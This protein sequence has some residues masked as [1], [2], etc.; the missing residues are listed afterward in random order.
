M[1]NISEVLNADLQTFLDVTFPIMRAC[2]GD[3]HVVALARP[4]VVE[5]MKAI[6]DSIHLAMI[7]TDPTPCLITKDMELILAQVSIR[8]KLLRE[9]FNITLAETA[10]TIIA[11]GPGWEVFDVDD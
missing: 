2:E 5:H 11:P 7:V 6:N 8:K 10:P 4:R 3:K 1:S 9:Q